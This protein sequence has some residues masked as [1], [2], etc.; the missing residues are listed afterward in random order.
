MA[1]FLDSARLN[2]RL[3]KWKTWRCLDKE[4]WP[5]GQIW[6]TTYFYVALK[7]RLCFL[8]FNNYTKIKK[9]VFHNISNVSVHNKVSLEHGHAHLFIYYQWLLSHYVRVVRLGNRPH[10]PQSLKYLLSG[11]LQEKFATPGLD[12]DDEYSVRI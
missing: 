5:A 1:W 2:V 7:L 12:D 4:S 10:D 8:F 3:K 6:L 11:S 9:T